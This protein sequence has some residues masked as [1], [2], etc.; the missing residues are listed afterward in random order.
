MKVD[1]FN[2]ELPRELIAQEPMKTRD[3]SRLM[4]LGLTGVGEEDVIIEHHR[5]RDVVDYLFPGDVIVMNDTKVEPCKLVGQK[6]T[7]AKAEIIVSRFV[8]D[9]ICEAQIKCNKVSIGM[10]LVFGD[11]TVN[12]M[13][14][15]IREVRGDHGV[16]E[17]E[18]DC[19]V[20]DILTTH[21]EVPLPPYIRKKSTKEEYQTVYAEKSGSIAAPT[22][23]FHFT[24]D[25]LELIKAKGVNIVKVTLHVSYGTFMPVKV[26]NVEEHKM[27]SEWY[28]VTSDVAHAINERKGRLIVVGTTA[29][30]TVESVT[31]VDGRVVPGSGETNIFI[32]PGYSFKLKLDMLI[33][34]F[35]LPK[36]TLLML[37]CALGGKERIM[38][39]Y[40]IAVEQKYRFFS[41]GDAMMIFVNKSS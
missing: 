21:G 40:N 35:H 6:K 22:A 5:F 15:V 37:V 39:A 41:F 33:T 1:E 3:E 34:N 28:E 25:L 32:Y 23:G 36:S 29:L 19:A 4:V 17:L 12:A 27:H 26:E 10:E 14:R 8:S 2:Y 20:K 38:N 7:G 31:G 16:F 24:K 30:R 11:S 18:F 9:R 13:A